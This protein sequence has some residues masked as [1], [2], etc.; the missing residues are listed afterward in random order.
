VKLVVGDEEYWRCSSRSP[1]LEVL[2]SS[3]DD[4]ED[5]TEDIDVF[6]VRKFGSSSLAD[7]SIY[8]SALSAISVL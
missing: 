6:G 4:L 2:F 7:F 8:L 1:A 3:D 5:R